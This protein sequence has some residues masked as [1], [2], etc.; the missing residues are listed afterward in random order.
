M[1]AAAIQRLVRKRHL[2]AQHRG[3]YRVGHGA[4]SVEAA[5]LG[6]VLACGE[7]AAIS[8]VAAAY[9][10]GLVRGRPPPAEVTTTRDRRPSGIRVRQSRALEP[11]DVIRVRGIP[12]TTVPRTLVD[13]AAAMTAGELARACH[14]AGVRYRTTPAEVEK[15]LERMPSPHGAAKIRAVL[16]G[17]VAVTLS[18]LERRFRRLLM[19]DGLDLPEM[20]RAVSGRRVD[21]RWAKHRLT[22]ELDSYRYHSSRHAWEQDRQ[23]ERGA[24][25]RGD[26]FRR[27]ARGDVFERPGQMLNELRPLLNDTA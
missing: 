21:C 25:A 3:V 24:Y 5:Y 7:G 23:R 9:L 20:N 18:A 11:R 27:Y 14:E 10:L 19:D 16:R 6:A 2:L 13:S 12:V 8:G 15:V 26:H 1:S 4:P 22:V 17:D